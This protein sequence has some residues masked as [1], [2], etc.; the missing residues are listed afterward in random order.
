[1]KVEELAHKKILVIGMGIEGAAT[2]RFLHKYVPTS[3]IETTDQKNGSGYLDS[4][5]DYDLAVKSPGVPR[6]LLHIPYTTATNIFFANT[7]GI[8]IGVTGTKGKSTTSSLI[9]SLLSAARKR[10]HLCGNIGRPL[11]DELRVG[12]DEKDI[13]VVEL[14]SYQLDDIQFSPHIA[15]FINIFPE[16]MNYHG[17]LENYIAAKKHIM[18]FATGQ[19]YFVYNDAYPMFTEFAKASN[20]KPTPFIRELPFPDSEIQLLGEHNKDNVRAA[21]TVGKLFGIPVETMRRAVKDFTPLPHRLQNVG[22]YDGI[23]FYDDAISTTPES[24]I[25]AIES[26]KPIGTILVGGLDR[27]YDFNK[28]ADVIIEHEIKNVI[29]FP[30]SGNKIA[31]FLKEKNRSISLFP[32]SDMDSAVKLSFQHTPKG[33][34]CLLSCA[35][36]SYSLWKNFEEKGDLFQKF[37]RH[38]A[39]SST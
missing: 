37:V 35:S 6:Q 26:L 2:V 14:S 28:L 25:V 7:K 9:Y 39:A 30:D 8:V 19:D 11:L 38:H 1:M 24:T 15:V 31:A 22:T 36:P 17:S 20:A 27:G 13:Y 12:E 16:H 34:I 3:T 29:Y 33:T 10:V 23:T 18:Q 5:A 4:Q 21:V 32:A